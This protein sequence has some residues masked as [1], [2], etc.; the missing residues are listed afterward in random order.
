MVMSRMSSPV[1]VAASTA[2]RA[3]RLQ[4]VEGRRRPGRGVRRARV[5]A[6]L[7]PGTGRAVRARV[8]A[9]VE[10]QPAP[11]RYRESWRSRLVVAGI[12]P[13]QVREWCRD[14]HRRRA[15]IDDPGVALPGS[16]R[17]CRPGRSRARR[18]CDCLRSGGR[19]RS[20]GSS[21]TSSC[22]CRSGTRSVEPG[23]EELNAKVGVVLPEGS[24]GA[25]SMV[26]SGAVR[27]TVQVWLAGVR[28]GVAR[29]VRGADV[30][31]V[32]AGAE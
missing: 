13:V 31:G 29:R 8:R 25:E 21:T 2:D 5:G 27:S 10:V 4:A 22:R 9:L 14:R 17:C 32:A 19:E 3:D 24:D 20:R 18:R 11:R 6:E 1:L 7:Q 23:S 12:R 16:R 28:I 30:E 15:R 26:V